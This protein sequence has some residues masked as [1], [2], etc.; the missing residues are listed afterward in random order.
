MANARPTSIKN[1]FDNK[2]NKEPALAPNT[3]LTPISF[4][5]CDAVN[6]DSPSNLRQDIKI[7]SPAKTAAR[8]PKH[9]A[10]TPKV[11][12]PGT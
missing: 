7:A 6:M 1:S 8:L 12:M 2:L 5:R 10:I 4:T 9:A 11:T 3:F